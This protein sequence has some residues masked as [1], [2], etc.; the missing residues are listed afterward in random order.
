MQLSEKALD[1]IPNGGRGAEG[2]NYTTLYSCFAMNA[3]EELPWMLAHTTA[4]INDAATVTV[5][6]EHQ[7]FPL[8]PGTQNSYVFCIL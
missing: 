3:S 5:K 8:T 1:S 4:T 2:D 7:R 6:S